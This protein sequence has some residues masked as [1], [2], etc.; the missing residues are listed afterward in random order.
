MVAAVLACGLFA[1]IASADIP[2][3][4]ITGQ[5]TVNGVPTAGV[6]V[7]AIPCDGATLPPDWPAPP[8]NTTSTTAGTG[9][10]YLLVF[11]TGFGNGA[12]PG[13]AGSVTFQSPANSAWYTA[14]DVQL[15]FSYPGYDPVILP[16]EKVRAAYEATLGNPDPG[17]PVINVDFSAPQ[18]SPVLVPGDTAGKGFWAN[19]N[20]QA[21]IKSLNGGLLS[22]QLANWLARNFPYLYG[23]RAGL[24]N[25]TGQ[26]NLTVALLAAKLKALIGSKPDTHIFATA[27]SVYVTDSDLAG[28]AA[29]KYGFNVSTT[30]TAEKTYNVGANGRAIGLSNNTSYTIMALLQQANLQVQLGKFDAKAFNAV[31]SDIAEAGDKE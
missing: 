3:V 31:F 14:I 7:E 23:S 30:G 18:P 12:T 22:T 21:L 16:C 4:D 26:P 2:Y 15:K 27:L 17:V 28:N 19:K 11:V 6:T 29:V 24:N 1:N 5:V 8:P 20:G 25:L 10:N 13:P 9:A